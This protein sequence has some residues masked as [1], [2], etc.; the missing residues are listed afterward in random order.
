MARPVSL[1]DLQQFIVDVD[2]V[3]DLAEPVL[4]LAE[5]ACCCGLVLR[6]GVAV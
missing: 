1:T 5:A 3:R 6:C 4:E 2:I